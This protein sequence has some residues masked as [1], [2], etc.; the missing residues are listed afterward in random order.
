MIALVP[1]SPLSATTPSQSYLVRTASEP[2]AVWVY[3][4]QEYQS[5]PGAELVLLDETGAIPLQISPVNL[6]S[7][8]E[9]TIIRLPIDYPLEPDQVYRWQFT[10]TVNPDD[11]NG[12]H[13]VGGLI[14]TVAPTGDLARQIEQAQP[15][16]LDQIY[17]QH[18]IWHDALTRL[19]ESRM[20]D[21]HNETLKASWTNLLASVG[22]GEL[23]DVPLGTCCQTPL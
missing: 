17:T 2:L 11:I 9:A 6:V 13:T 3:I 10:V 15:A 12:N 22:L 19:G 16:N 4:P 8:S 1:G 18:D 7:T 14:E 21:P 5:A 23:A 20:A